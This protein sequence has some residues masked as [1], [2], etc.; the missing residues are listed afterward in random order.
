MRLRPSSDGLR[1]AGTRSPFRVRAVGGAL[2]GL[3]LAAAACGGGGSPSAQQPAATTSTTAPPINAATVTI[4][5]QTVA[6][7]REA[8]NLPANGRV[9]TGQNVIWTAQ[10]FL[11]AWLFAAVGQ[12]IVFTNLSSQ[13]VTIKCVPL[14]VSFAVAPGKSYSLT[15]TAGIDQFQYSADSGHY[16]GKAQVGIFDQ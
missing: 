10:G 6:V 12:P 9:A 7:P 5:G 8:N 15:P 13:P 1:H 2:A 4:N 3:A 14:D 11:P 16:F